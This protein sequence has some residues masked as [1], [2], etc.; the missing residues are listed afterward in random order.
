VDKEQQALA[1]R[2]S[3]FLANM[4]HELRTPLNSLL[5]LAKLLADNR[6]A[7][8]SAKEVEYARTIHS[9]GTELLELIDGILDLAKAEAGKT[10]LEPRDLEFASIRAC[11]ERT[12]A[13]LADDQGLQFHV[14]LGADL[15]A[16]IRTD[17]QR[18]QQVLKNLLSNAFK[19][20][21]RGSV[22]L[23]IGRAAR[24]GGREIA[25]CVVDTGIGIARDQQGLI[26]EAFQQVDDGIARRYGGTGLGLSISREIARRLGGEIEVASEPSHGSTFTLYL[27][28]RLAAS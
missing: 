18:L 6:D 8:L 9:S 4:S 19:F 5:I 11:A 24:D 10:H 3:Q 27:P 14:E 1:R 12:F 16:H 13:P 23:R 2:Q 22:L 25:F 15:P 28:E 26:F 20:T 21:E 7:H 17:P